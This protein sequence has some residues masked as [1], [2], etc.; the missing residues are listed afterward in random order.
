MGRPVMDVVA[1]GCCRHALESMTD[2][3]HSAFTWCCRA[4]LKHSA[5]LNCAMLVANIADGTHL[6]VHWWHQ[7]R[8]RMA[9]GLDTPPCLSPFK[10]LRPH[11]RLLR[12]SIQRHLS[13]DAPANKIST[14]ASN[15]SIGVGI[16]S[17]TVHF[18]TS[19]QPHHTSWKKYIKKLKKLFLDSSGQNRSVYTGL[20]IYIN[21]PVQ[22][23]PAWFVRCIPYQHKWYHE[24]KNCKT[25]FYA[26]FNPWPYRRMYKKIIL[27]FFQIF[28][29]ISIAASFFITRLLLER[30]H[31][32]FAWWWLFITFIKTDCIR[33][34]LC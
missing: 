7:S 12:A 19:L 4:A 24:K 27:A 18:Y 20:S 11:T 6:D 2:G 10:H 3:I 17:G 33:G 26:M 34:L 15:S 22:R 16:Q 21:K 9:S 14:W 8:R 1:F 25:W 23:R 31:S 30:L 5:S 29:Y 13:W 28:W 32:V